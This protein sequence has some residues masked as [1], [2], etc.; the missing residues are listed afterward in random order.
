M[1]HLP[2]AFG[3]FVSFVIAPAARSA[4][5]PQP[6][7]EEGG[8]CLRL[9]VKPVEGEAAGFDVQL[10]LLN[11]SKKAITLRA[12]WRD[13]RELGD[14]R[15]YL[16]AAASIESYPAVA[17]WIGGVMVPHRKL[18][19]PEH[20]LEAGKTLSMSWRSKGRRLKNR[21]TDPS[22]VQNPDF[23]FAGLYSVHAIVEVITPDRTV[24]LR[25]N[26]QLVPVG[27][28]RAMPRST[29][30]RI[31]WVK[32]DGKEAILAL[33]SRHQVSV[34]DE[35]A[36]GHPKS[37]HWKLTITRVNPDDARGNIEPLWSLNPGTD[38]PRAHMTAKL[39]IKDE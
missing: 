30:G 37:G 35:F 25:S 26:E 12:A 15:A 39:M 36:I 34:G 22:V 27:G 23:P 18:P 11:V 10:D 24:R 14:V 31:Q 13:D 2:L 17:P 28:S 6:G 8:L 33:G 9:I 16:E 38:I 19:Q 21:V 29:Y 7:P 4:D 5:A 20:V 32:P 1:K 3:L